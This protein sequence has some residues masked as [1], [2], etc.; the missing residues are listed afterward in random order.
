MRPIAVQSLSKSLSLSLSLAIVIALLQFFC[1]QQIAF[2][3]IGFQMLSPWSHLHGALRLLPPPHS[4]L[5]A[6]FL[7]C[8]LRLYFS[9]FCFLHSFYLL[10][11]VFAPITVNPFLLSAFKMSTKPRASTHQHTHT[12]TRIYILCACP[13][14][15]F[16]KRIKNRKGCPEHTHVPSK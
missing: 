3:L 1:G 7:A 16:C 2:T 10:Y 5:P 8:A 6:S 15:K 4:P 14:G 9:W 11:G 13:F 12:H